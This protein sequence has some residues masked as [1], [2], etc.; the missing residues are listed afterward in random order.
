ME[1]GSRLWEAGG[2]SLWHREEGSVFKE[3]GLG[4]MCSFMD[5]ASSRV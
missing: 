3:T 2:Q 4:S 5:L 1:A